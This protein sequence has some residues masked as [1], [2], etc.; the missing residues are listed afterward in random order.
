MPKIAALIILLVV[1]QLVAL[2]GG[3]L[4]GGETSLMANTTN[5]CISFTYKLWSPNMAAPTFIIIDRRVTFNPVAVCTT[6]AMN[7][8]SCN[9]DPGTPML[10]VASASSTQISNAPSCS[11]NCGGCGTIVTDGPT[12]GLPVELMDFG[13]EH[14]DE[15][16]PSTD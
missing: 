15:E 6:A 9:R 16:P 10:L 3:A 2:A 14:E 12:V 4:A 1:A 13:F 5:A 8:A 7:N 11:W